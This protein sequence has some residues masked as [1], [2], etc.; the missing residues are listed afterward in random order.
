MDDID[1]LRVLIESIE[2]DRRINE[3]ALRQLKAA[4]LAAMTELAR[5]EDNDLRLTNAIRGLRIALNNLT[6]ERNVGTT[7]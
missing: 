3:Q 2:Q 4:A 7:G 5:A 1:S 6:S